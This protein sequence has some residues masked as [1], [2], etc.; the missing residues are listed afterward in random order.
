MHTSPYR[1]RITR[2]DGRAINV[3]Q[4][5]AH[6][7]FCFTGCCCGRTDRGYLPVPA[8]LFKEEWLRRKIR[9]VVHLTKA[10][11]L[12]PCALANVASLV[13]DT[14]SVWF[15][16]ISQPWQVVAIFDYIEAMLA[17]DRYLPPP[18]ELT[19]FTFNYYD[20]DQRPRHA[21]DGEDSIP[22]NPN[23]IAFLTHADTDLL[24]LANGR[25]YLPE[26]LDVVGQSLL[27]LRDEESMKALCAGRLRE[28]AAILLR[29]HG[30]PEQ[31]PGFDLLRRTARERGQRLAL[32]SGIGEMDPHLA[33]CGDVPVDVLGPLTAYFSQ[34]GMGNVTEAFRFFSDRILMSGYGYADPVALPLHGVYLPDI[35]S[36]TLEDWQR[37]ADPGK[38]TA[39]VLFYRAH[40]LC[41]NTVFVDTLCD[42][43]SAEGFN[44]L[45]V[46]TASLR[47]EIEGMPH[48]LDLARGR[49][50][51]L[52]STLSFAH[53]DARQGSDSVRQT[54]FAELNI[55]VLQAIASG[56]PE[57]NWQLSARGLTPLDT[58]INV[59]LPEFDG[60][61]ITVP[62]SFKDRHPEHQTACYAPKEDR[63]ARMAGMARRWVQLQRLPNEQKRV[64]F[65]LT[66]SSAKASQIGNAVGLDAPASLLNLLRGMRTRG[67]HVEDLPEE[68]DALMQALLARGCYDEEHPLD[69]RNCFRLSA[70]TYRACFN[71]FPETVRQK[72]IKSWGEPGAEP[73]DCWRDTRG[74]Q[75]AGLEFGNALVVLQPPRG[76]GMD[77]NEIYHRPDLPPTHHYA[78]FYRWLALPQQQGGWGADAIVHVG[79]H[80]TLEWLPGKGIG[81][82][83]ECFPDIL[84]GDLPLIYPFIINDPGEGSQ[85]K[86]RGHAVI[87][88]HMTPPMTVAE[89]YGPLAELNE[90]V[91]AYYSTE[92]LDPTKLPIVQR[93][94]WDL[95]EQTNL[96]AD[97]NLTERLAEDHGDHKHTWDDQKTPEGVP[98]TLAG[99]SGSEVAHLIEDI[100]GYLCELGLA[101]IRDGL[102]TLGEM[103]SLPAML[104]ALTRL[105]NAAVPSLH[106]SIASALGST[107]SELWKHPGRRLDPP[108]V[109]LGKTCHAHAD[110]LELVEDLAVELFTKLEED[111]YR[112]QD[113]E[114]LST[115]LLGRLSPDA[116]AALRY[117]CNE[118][119]P[120]LEHIDGEI[121]QVLNALEGRY[122]PPG[123]SGA[124]TRGNAHILPTGRNFYAVDPR[125]LPSAAAWQVGQQL[126]RETIERYQREEGA[127][128][129]SVGLSLWGTS[130]MRTQGDDVAEVL[131]FLG[132]RPVWNAYSRR[133]ET[134]EAIP[135]EELGRPRIDVT[136]RISGFFRDAFPH[137]IELL[138]EAMELVMLLPEP[139]E[140]NFPRKHY[141][142]DL[143][144]NSAA[145]A[146]EAEAKARFR[147]FGAKPGAYGAGLLPLIEAGNWQTTQDLAN[148]FLTWGSYAYGRDAAGVEA[149]ESF[150]NR[151]R[152][153]Q[154]ALHNQD[155]REHDIFDSDDY[156]QFHGGMVATVRALTGVQPKAYFGDSSKPDNARIRSLREEALRVY[157]SRVVNPKW[158]ESIQRHGYKGGLELA[159]T[160]DYIFGF[161]ATARIVPDFVYQGLAEH[162]ALDAAMQDFLRRSNPWAINAIG[163]RL[164]EAAD[165]GLWK[166]PD[167]GT[168]DQLRNLLE[169]N[170]DHLE[171]RE[172]GVADHS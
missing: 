170:A 149:R 116:A 146:E 15:H 143:A 117:A 1:Q 135:L 86:R 7:S 33:Q 14:R 70:P 53:G 131:A 107:W 132:V 152:S 164:L 23:L 159:A 76:Y 75:F 157:R 150:E 71:Q 35:E 50:D 137:L 19:A 147:I 125:A 69:Q 141:L 3:V 153:V 108:C 13:F 95:V 51:I 49:A 78:A 47:D 103:P 96:M 84:L 97:L 133:I 43:L 122:I 162:Y 118:L 94:I 72:L 61:I 163:R 124:P 104:A 11:C 167:P 82:S 6:L 98:V 113:A 16:S 45:A 171:L 73:I 102:H 134:V 21:D 129:E 58:A 32:I 138:D 68:S 40:L 87:V 126:A 55:P 79:K 62:V 60:R 105:P 74:Y 90:L 114:A 36:A 22:V 46:Y 24:A 9:N 106:E 100:D 39:A 112:E 145:P 65:V 110:V 158:I 101:Q 156:F 91:N 155:N 109:L 161:D 119:V 17:A 31:I 34:G 83:A 27:A 20:W 85:A 5:R 10:G 37:R 168:L 44:P 48:A 136:M 8:D 28:A 160:V 144:A 151:L 2:A 127:Y 30:S 154:V 111:G 115:A 140:Q 81:L 4:K 52:I 123:P 92:K 25:P 41:G 54:A 165:R 166:E 63:I 88:D 142:A 18:L 130:Q 93:R 120:K 169:A 38:P 64:A 66:N 29:L 89:T 80:G 128:P 12:G 67:Y 59:A 99:M 57:A 77:P 139:V 26:G 121:W 172:E 56:M 148:V 42:A